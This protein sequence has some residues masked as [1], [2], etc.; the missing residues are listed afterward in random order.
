MLKGCWLRLVPGYTARD[1]AAA[2]E[3]GVE[4]DA[5]VVFFVAAVGIAGLVAEDESPE[6]PPMISPG[7]PHEARAKIMQAQQAA[8]RN[9]VTTIGSIGAILAAV[10]GGASASSVGDQ[11]FA[12]E[13]FARLF[14]AQ[15]IGRQ[16]NVRDRQVIIS[17]RRSFAANER[18]QLIKTALEGL[19][20][21]SIDGG[22]CSVI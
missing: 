22:D 9:L 5:R 13:F 18:Q 11:A 16:N 15:I 6:P 20:V 7:L 8:A 21:A 14:E 10:A 1:A 3:T 12:G 17:K 2:I 19:S 4:P